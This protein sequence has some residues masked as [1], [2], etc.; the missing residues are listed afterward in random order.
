MVPVLVSFD[1]ALPVVVSQPFTTGD[2]SF[3]A[4]NP[5]PWRELEISEATLFE[6]WRSGLV[7]CELL[8]V[9]VPALPVVEKT[10]ELAHTKR[11]KR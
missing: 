1:A 10:P 8:P 9:A 4:D 5:F 2:R 3:R 7:R 11:A 6:L